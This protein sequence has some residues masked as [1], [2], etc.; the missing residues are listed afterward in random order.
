MGDAL[1]DLRRLP[2]E[3]KSA[4]GYTLHEIQSG[5]IP[6]NVKYLRGFKPAVMEIS[7]SHNT[8]AYRVIYTVKIDETIYVLHCFQKKSKKGAQTP[9]QD[10]NLIKQRLQQAEL[11]NKHKG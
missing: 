3:V 6:A 8:N 10:I 7:L 1:E 4:A 9:R 2:E 11:I 5:A